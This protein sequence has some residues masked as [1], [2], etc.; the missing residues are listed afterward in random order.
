M[1]NTIAPEHRSRRRERST[2]SHR[3]LPASFRAP[4]LAC[5]VLLFACMAFGTL[6]FGA[7]QPWS[8]WVLE[9]GVAAVALLWITASAWR[10]TLALTF[11]PIHLCGL[12]FF[13]VV[14]LQLLFRRTAYFADTYDQALVALMDGIVFLVATEMFQARQSVVSFF[15]MATLFG[16]AYALFATVYQLTAN[17]RIFWLIP[18]HHG[19]WIYGSYVNHNH[20]AGLMELL[21][22][23]A[24]LVPLLAGHSLPG[25]K[26]AVALFCGVV[27]SATIFLSG[28]RGGM[29]SFLLQLVL[30]GALLM[31]GR[32]RVRSAVVF[33]VLIFGL[34]AMVYWIGSDVLAQRLSSTR[35]QDPIR[36]AV[37]RDAWPM[38]KEHFWFGWGLGT[39]PTVY[40]HFRS[41]Y[42]DL[43]VNE[44]HNDYVQVLLETGI[45]GFS[46][47]LG[48]LFFLYRA[49]LRE[50]REE[51]NLQ[52]A[53]KIAALVGCSGIVCHSIID[54]N[55]HVPANELW[56][57]VLCAIVGAE[58]ERSRRSKVVSFSSS[59][60]S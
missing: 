60:K 33:L 58:K 56:Y 13:L 38:L 54:F 36:L 59:S 19:G 27:M 35:L 4:E 34:S 10:G 39:F 41:I 53:I 8:V 40:P 46:A 29:F 3:D 47:V 30:S 52:S 49:G 23:L 18:I 44:A 7:T 6:A 15:W 48:F 2:H 11:S 28:S 24:L 45:L 1:T 12:A 20:Y 14:G 31:R 9:A 37:N 42:T 55:L 25:E 22:P 43:F 5:V 21:A 16:G 51:R 57:F 50:V 17:D 32:S 26:Q